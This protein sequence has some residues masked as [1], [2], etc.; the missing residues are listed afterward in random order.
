MMT[1]GFNIHLLQLGV[2]KSTK[3]D[4]KVT[5]SLRKR[6]FHTED[7]SLVHNPVTTQQ[8]YKT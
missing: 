3:K 7:N 4:R 6:N 8:N 2:A 1:I 5:A